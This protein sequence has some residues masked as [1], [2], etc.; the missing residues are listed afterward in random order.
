MF[1]FFEIYEGF[2]IYTFWLTLT[3]CFFLFIWMLK[4]L[5]FK[6]SY[7]LSFFTKNIVWYFISVFIF[8]RLFFV[9][10]KWSDLVHIRD[11]FQFFITSD[12]NFSL[13]W[14]IFWFFLVLIINLKLKKEKLEKYID[15][16]M[17]SFFFVLFIWYLWA[18][19]G[20]QVYGRETTIWI[21]I[22]Y[23]HPFTK[24][25]YEVAIFPLPVI[26]SI[27]F[28]I[29]FSIFYIISMYLGIRWFIGYLWLIVFSST[30]LVLEFFSWKYDVF[31]DNLSFN[32]TQA[33]SIIIIAVSSYF[34]YKIVN[35]NDIDKD[36]LLI[37]S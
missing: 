35:N 10:S 22:L 13:I 14:A 5:S 2:L 27:V 16:V 3:F 30:I 1:P 25:P 31:K 37:K 36:D 24:V 26:Y 7:D 28:F 18:L 20:W 6:Y 33:L 21:E 23:T 32:F 17:L 8:S 34:L 29:E 11:P 19:L 12:Y 4:K 15:G 9:I